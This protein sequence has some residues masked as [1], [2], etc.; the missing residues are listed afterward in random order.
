MPLTKKVD[1]I[2]NGKYVLIFGL[3]ITSLDILS[4]SL[5]CSLAMVTYCKD[6][7]QRGKWVN[8]Q[9]EQFLRAN[10]TRRVII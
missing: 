7:E 3:A 1:G 6:N 5:S 9:F 2:K 8:E 4:C 10:L